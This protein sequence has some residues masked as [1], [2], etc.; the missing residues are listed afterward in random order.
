V[1]LLSEEEAVNFLKKNI[2][3]A[4]QIGNINKLASVLQCLPLALTQVNF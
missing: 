1:G 2:P 3:K 4:K